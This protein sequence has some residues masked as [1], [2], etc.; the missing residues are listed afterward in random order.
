VP[1]CAHTHTHTHTHTPA[2][3][4]ERRQSNEVKQYELYG[5][6]KEVMIMDRDQWVNLSRMPFEKE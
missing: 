1:E 5:D 6:D 2:L 3:L 4:M